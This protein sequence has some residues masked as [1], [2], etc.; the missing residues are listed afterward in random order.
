MLSR[1]S[2]FHVSNSTI[3]QQG[4]QHVT[5]R[6]KGRILYSGIWHPLFLP[7]TKAMPKEF[8]PS[9]VECIFGRQAEQLGL[10]H[11]ILCAERVVGDE[12][13]AVLLVDDF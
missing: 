1:F 13:F 2:L 6:T 8:L 10:G 12:P 5:H 7:V 11:A 9:G 3:E 4:Y